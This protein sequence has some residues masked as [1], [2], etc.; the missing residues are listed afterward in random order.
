MFV[1]STGP[2]IQLHAGEM[3]DVYTPVLDDDKQHML[4]SIS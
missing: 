4:V 1:S 2:V 3:D